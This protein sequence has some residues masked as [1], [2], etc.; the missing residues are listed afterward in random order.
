M[1]KERSVRKGGKPPYGNYDAGAHAKQ[2]KGQG[3]GLAKEHVEGGL[4]KEDSRHERS[5]RANSAP[6]GNIPKNHEASDLIE[7]SGEGH[8]KQPGGKSIGVGMGEGAEHHKG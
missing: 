1:E 2:H 8:A 7:E 6:V 4:K 5:E 3:I